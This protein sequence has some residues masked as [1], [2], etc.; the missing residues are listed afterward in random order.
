M[1]FVLFGREFDVFYLVSQ[2]FALAAMILSL[3]AFQRRKKVQILNYTVLSAVCSVFHYL[4]LGAWA[5]VAT[6]GVGVVRNV[7]GAYEASKHKT[8]KIAPL[9][10]VSFYIV[11]GFFTYDSPISLLPVV[12]ASLYTIAIYFGDASKLRRV[13]VLTSGLWLIYDICVLSIVGI[14]AEAVFIFNDLIAIYRY[15]KK[16]KAKKRKPSGKIRGKSSKSRGR[17]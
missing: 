6:K 1:D 12:A 8:S 11:S 10:F 9:F 7:F 16:K 17:G 4:F 5:G 13:A 14:V 2:G 15:R 3:Y